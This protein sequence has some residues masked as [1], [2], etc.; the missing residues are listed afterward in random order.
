VLVA[1]GEVRGVP[2][3]KIGHHEASGKRLAELTWTG[4]G[5][6]Q[7]AVPFTPEFDRFDLEDVRWYHENYRLNWRATSNAVIER[8]Q[9]AERKIGE[10]LHEALF[11]GQAFP[12]AEKVRSA[13]PDLRIEVRD[14]VHSAGIPW[15]LMADP[16][17]GEQLALTASSF[18]R[19][20]GTGTSPPAEGIV[21]RDTHRLLVLIS[22]PAWGRDVGYW[23]VAYA[24]WRDL[25]RLPWVKIDVLRPPT[26]DALEHCLDEAM[27]NGTPYTAVHF[28]GHG[29]I[30]DP[31]GGTRTRGYLAFETAG[32]AGPDFLDGSTLGGALAAA[33]VLLF[34]MNA[35]RSADPEGGDRHL[36][37]AQEADTGQPSIVEEVL[38]AGVPACIGMRRE[39]YP[40]TAARF[41]SVFYPE[42]FGGRS[43]G[44]AS[45]IARCRLHEE[46]LAAATVREGIAPIEDWSIPVI[47]E[48]AAV[49][50]PRTALAQQRE[51]T[52]EAEPGWLPEHLSAPQ[53]VGFDMMVPVLED[54]LAEASV[55]LVHG[56]LLSGKSRLAVE[57]AR[58][59]STTTPAPCPVHYVRLSVQD[60]PG[61]V[62]T[63]ILSPATTATSPGSADPASCAE[64]LKAQGG[65]LIIDQADYLAPA[66]GAFLAEILTRL[67][68]ACR[69]LV[70][71]RTGN[72]SWLPGCP[73]VT[74]DYLPRSARTEL[75]RYWADAAGVQF[76]QAAV[77]QLLFFSG[78]LPGMILLLL[79]A[80]HDLISN[81]ATSANEIS[82]W[83]DTADWGQITCLASEPWPGLPS[84]EKLAQETAADLSS[85]CSQAELTAIRV[86]ARF[87]A[88]C[89]EDTAARLLAKASGTTTSADGASPIFWTR[90]TAGLARYLAGAGSQARDLH[91][92]LKLDAARLLGK[93]AAAGL[94]EH[95][96]GAGRPAWYLHPLLKLV[97]SRLPGTA[98]LS[99]E[100]LEEAFTDVVSRT[101]ADLVAGFRSD[102]ADVVDM[103]ALYKQNISSANLIALKRGQLEA[104]SHLTEGLCLYC[105]FTGDVDL[106][107]NV[108]DYGLPDFIDT[109]T[110]ALR[111]ECSEFGLRVWEQAIQV[112]A[113]W[114]RRRDP[115]RY[116]RVR[117][118]PPE[119]DHYATGIWLRAIGQT[120]PAA[121]EFR[122]ELSTPSR[123]PRYSPGDIECYLVEM[124]GQQ[125]R[126]SDALQMSL[127][128]YAARLPGDTIG[129][130]WSRITEAR[131][132]MM[133]VFD[134]EDCQDDDD[135]VMTWVRVTPDDLAALNEIADLLREAQSEAGGQSAEARAQAAMLWCKIM[136][137]RGDLTSA[138][139]SFEEGTSI[140][141]ALEENG[142][143]RHYWWF[144]LNL[145]RYGWIARGYEAA[146]NA[147][148]Y[149]MHAGPVLV[150]HRTCTMIREFCQQLET[151]YPEQTGR[152][153]SRFRK[154][155]S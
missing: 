8:I 81:G 121:D 36:R 89:D 88:F 24:L 145:V 114:P 76:D 38:A 128:S 143:W 2:V 42:F 83:L 95:F 116:D 134:H 3:L 39:T 33:G 63:R 20:P 113:Y 94:A 22:R 149:A 133:M 26:F 82:K 151:A 105:G 15:E 27:R 31:S 144:A 54:K 129:R 122:A 71:A 52:P 85:A 11:Q 139:S 30:A 146:V 155:G 9:R 47:G 21:P 106:L 141:M 103:L 57:Y 79:G 17:S 12:L 69:V 51:G 48:R 138:V 7:V 109:R 56:P 29:E 104:A 44:E 101:C 110:G 53:V 119:N 70:T 18:V 132:R 137:I 123:S 126:W 28:D 112:S 68:G 93:L 147:F 124:L 58:W 86:L 65:I 49:R 135:D 80:A 90:V 35:C 78:G 50:L 61:V 96:A 117:L 97:A 46:P 115:M 10:A 40:G 23:S 154:P 153:F 125:R 1:G 152:D 64:Y 120:E 142:I 150:M 13:G 140:M 19:V 77:H 131:I 37:T 127:Q 118:T 45:K 84:I 6:V 99:D 4:D 75:G 91:P 98:G 92:Q 16:Q 55:V 25:A 74:P 62:A 72:L 87:N 60:T 148:Q 130:A 41:F 5:Y 43:A 111:P 34:S 102:T 107:S 67:G 108:L 100:D 59:L 14:E 32:R 136:L 73:S 66:T